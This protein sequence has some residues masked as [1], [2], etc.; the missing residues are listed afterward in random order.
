MALITGKCLLALSLSICRPFMAL[1]TGK[2]LLALSLFI[3]RP[4]CTYKGLIHV[5]AF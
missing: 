3:C 2:G 5:S 4:W 1:I